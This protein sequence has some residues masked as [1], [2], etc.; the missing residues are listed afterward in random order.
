MAKTQLKPKRILVFL[1]G[2]CFCAWQSEAVD[3][4]TASEGQELT[5]V[6]LTFIGCQYRLKHRNA[7]WLFE[8]ALSERWQ[9]TSKPDWSQGKRSFGATLS[10]HYV[11]GRQ[12]TDK[13]FTVTMTDK[14]SAAFCAVSLG[15]QPVREDSLLAKVLFAILAERTPRF[16]NIKMVDDEDIVGGF[17]PYEMKWIGSPELTERV[18]RERD[19]DFDR[20]A[21]EKGPSTREGRQ[22]LV[23]SLLKKAERTAK[24]GDFDEALDCIDQA[25][26]VP[27]DEDVVANSGRTWRLEMRELCD[28]CRVYFVYLPQGNKVKAKEVLRGMLELHQSEEWKPKAATPEEQ[29]RLEEIN[30]QALSHI[31]KKLMQVA[32]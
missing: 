8:Q 22:M 1:L 18:S 26:A 20:R 15:G 6:E 32:E 21:V 31:R 24:A 14:G 27:R 10:L 2:A 4:A 3:G 30:E 25:Q 16:T 29:K 5:G 12:V 13:T 28:T 19:E 11:S 7:M 17:T 23:S 9:A